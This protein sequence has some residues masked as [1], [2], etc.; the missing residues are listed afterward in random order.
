MV[1]SRAMT[2]CVVLAASM[3]AVNGCGLLGDDRRSND[4]TGGRLERFTIAVSVMPTIDLAPF[5]LAVKK[6]YFAALGLEVTFA[7][8]PSGQ[9][10][11]AKLI[12]GDVDIAYSSYTPFFVA[13]SQR[14]ADL[15]FV[16]E[17][18]AAGP[19]TT[20]VVTLP[21][22]P[23]KSV[24]DLAGKRIAVTGGTPSPTRW[25]RRR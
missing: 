14:A 21:N 4:E 2:L 25:S 20:V 16:A 7:N 8:A 18:S 5:H 22:S 17:A 19:N 24:R 9:A 10:S 1:R 6:G 11:L 23:I 13:Q 12:G 15:R 3:I